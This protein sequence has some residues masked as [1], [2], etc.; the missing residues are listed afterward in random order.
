MKVTKI[1]REECPRDREKAAIERGAARMKNKG[2]CKMFEIKQVVNA[3]DIS[4]T[5]KLADIIWREHFTQLLPS[6]QVDY[7]LDKFQ[8][9]T[10]MT[11]Q[12]GGD[13]YKYYL[14]YVENVPVGYCAVKPEADGS[15][16]LSKL[17]VKLEYRGQ[18]ISRK[19]LDFAL[20]NE[21]DVARIHLT[22]NRYNADSI[23]VYKHLGFAV[24]GEKATD[25]GGGYVM[26]DY[27]MEVTL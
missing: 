5:A 27:L 14:A 19:L 1:L 17:Y 9:E 12:I 10:A 3:N 2:E 26:D 18:G 4:V 23:A 16:F 25:I 15:L 22:V 13:G 7:M 21:K 20:R 8:S 11:R 6:G 24:Y